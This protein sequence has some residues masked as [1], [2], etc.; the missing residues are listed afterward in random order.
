MLYLFREIY[1]K[2]E[3]VSTSSLEEY[4]KE[5]AYIRFRGQPVFQTPIDS[6]NIISNL[7]KQELLGLIKLNDDLKGPPLIKN[8]D[9]K[10]EQVYS[11]TFEGDLAT[12]FQ[13]LT[14]WKYDDKGKYVGES[15]IAILGDDIEEVVSKEGKGEKRVSKG[16]LLS[17]FLNGPMKKNQQNIKKGS[18]G[19]LPFGNSACHQATLIRDK[20]QHLLE[21]IEDPDIKKF[22]NISDLDDCSDKSRIYNEFCIFM[23]SKFPKLPYAIYIVRSYFGNHQ[24]LTDHELRDKFPVDPMRKREDCKNPDDLVDGTDVCDR[25]WKYRIQKDQNQAF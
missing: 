5:T 9:H 24:T 8:F 17:R 7:K 21:N 15:W 23:L 19:K 14:C 1:N 22:L 20:D 16:D 3:Y 6:V 4:F 11:G 25:I 12:D 13:K 18:P 10:F 2:S